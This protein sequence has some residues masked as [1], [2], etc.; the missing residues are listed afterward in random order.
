MLPPEGGRLQIGA[1]TASQEAWPEV[2]AG[3][4]ISPS[5]NRGG[6]PTGERIPQDARP[7]Q[8]H[9]RLLQASVGVPLPFFF[10]TR[11]HCERSEAI[12]SGGAAT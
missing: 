2:A 5:E 8:L 6:T 9:G 12:Q 11:R 3:D 4:A 7:C 1:L 10:L